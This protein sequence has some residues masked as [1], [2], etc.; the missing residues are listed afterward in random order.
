MEGDK[1]GD[2]GRV[3]G[4]VTEREGCTSMFITF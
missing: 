4:N 1:Y 2:M 3:A